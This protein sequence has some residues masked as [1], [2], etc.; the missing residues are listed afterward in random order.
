MSDLEQF[1][2]ETRQWLE[3]NCPASQR[4]TLAKKDVV[5]PGRKQTFPSEDAKLWFERM[6]DVGWT[7]P[8]FPVEYG[9]GGLNNE[10]E[11]VLKEEMKKLNCR[12]PVTDQG[13]AMLGPALLEFGNDAQKAFHIPKIVRGE[14][15]WC[16]GYSEPG[17][18]S[19]LASLKCKATDKGDYFLINGSKIWTSYGCESDWIFCLVRTSDEGAKQAGI[20]FLLIDMQSAGVSAKAIDLISGESEFAQVFFDDVKVPKENLV[21]EV[22]KGWSVAKGLLKHERK[23][24]AELGSGFAAG[25]L[26]LPKLAKQYLGESEQGRVVDFATRLS[27]ADYELRMRA[28]GLTGLRS[29]Q[30][31]I[32]GQLDSNVLLTMKYLG[33]SAMQIRD[34]LALDILGQHGMG[35]RDNRFTE[36]ELRA[37]RDTLF[38][39]ALTIAG[40]TSEIQLNI[41]AKRALDLPDAAVASRGN[42]AR[43]KVSDDKQSKEKSV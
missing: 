15:R 37:A 36:A 32:A 7:C 40:G 34:E 21:G 3:A 13:I 43:N 19:D 16:Q 29:H 9:G 33:T 28:V 11:K 42:D 4:T 26:S 18:G 10:Q 27:I 8:T 30:E 41:I 31:G 35:W 5:W 23:M 12:P 25:D 17:A 39:K 24:M 1:R 22:N 6:R 2:L 20:S 14:L 38:N